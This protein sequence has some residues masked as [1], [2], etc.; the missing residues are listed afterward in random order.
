MDDN[1]VIQEFNVEKI[2]D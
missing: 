2:W 1:T